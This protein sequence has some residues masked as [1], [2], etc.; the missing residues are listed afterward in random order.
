MA[1]RLLLAWCLTVQAISS[2]PP[3]AVT[4]VTDANF[5]ALTQSASRSPHVF[6]LLTAR[7]PKYGCPTCKDFEAV[8]TRVAAAFQVEQQE[9]IAAPI[10]FGVADYPT[11][12]RVFKQFGV[13]T[14]PLLY[15]FGKPPLAPD[16]FVLDSDTDNFDSV[17][18]FVTMHTGTRL[19]GKQP[20]YLRVGAEGGGGGGGAALF[21]LLALTS[22]SGAL[23]FYWRASLGVAVLSVI[24]WYQ[25]QVLLWF[26]GGLSLYYIAVSGV[27]FDVIKGVPF[28]G[29]WDARTGRFFIML[30]Q[31]GSQ[32]VA[33]G[34]L[35]GVLNVACAA[36]VV[37]LLVLL[38]RVRDA[39]T[40]TLY[41]VSAVATFVL[42]YSNVVAMYRMKHPGY[43]RW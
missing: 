42:C 2:P 21:S 23:L 26:L 33:E 34:L 27:L 14:V 38:P 17:A 8:I 6:I 12:S 19:S 35:I 9:E 40:R 28:A 36:S 3:P 37:A 16:Q 4:S 24:A 22:V 31:A 43:M 5:D 15:H 20:A 1:Q 7:D 18:Y 41:G 32:S 13:D 10:I 11:A 29:G 25:R 30:P 39:G